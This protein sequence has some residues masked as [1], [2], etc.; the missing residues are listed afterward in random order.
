MRYILNIGCN[1]NEKPAFSPAFA[2]S[3]V[4]ANLDVVDSASFTNSYTNDKG[5][6]V[7]EK[8]LVVL[9]ED[10]LEGHKL[11]DISVEVFLLS[12]V[13]EQW[14]IAY[15]PESN[16]E[17]GA[18]E[19]PRKTEWSGGVFLKEFFVTL[20]EA[21]RRE[22]SELAKNNRLLSDLGVAAPFGV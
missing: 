21:K 16:L 11:Y 18:L 10:S 12:A 4:H 3:K 6:T 22:A 7:E 8:T 2:L 19:G 20:D 14:A 15:A 1:V 13:L 5:E 17:L 9:V